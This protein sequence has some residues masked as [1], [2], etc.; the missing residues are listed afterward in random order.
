MARWCISCSRTTAMLSTKK[1]V[2]GFTRHSTAQRG[3]SRRARQSPRQTF[4]QRSGRARAVEAV[5]GPV[6]APRTRAGD[7]PPL[8]VEG[9][10]AGGS[11][12]LLGRARRCRDRAGGP[13]SRGLAL[14]ASR[15]VATSPPPAAANAVPRLLRHRRRR[16]S[17]DNPGSVALLARRATAPAVRPFWFGANRRRTTTRGSWARRRD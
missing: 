10:Q 3:K 12:S 2:P 14:S 16:A 8:V 9:E 5:R 15:P 17:R 7:E 4:L 1:S 11:G 13:S 6:L